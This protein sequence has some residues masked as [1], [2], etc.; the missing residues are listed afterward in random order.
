MRTSVLDKKVDLPYYSFDKVFSYNAVFN[1][2]VGA[3]GLG[4]TYG[5]KKYVIKNAIK[6]GEQFIY[7]RRYKTELTARTTFFADIFQEFPDHDFRVNGHQA[8]MAPRETRDDKKRKWQVIGYFAALSNAQSKKSVAY[9]AVTMILFDEF[10]IEKGALHYLPNEA[11]AFNDF[12]S[13]V[14]RWKDKTRVLFMANSVSIMNPYFLEYDIKPEDA[15]DKGF[16]RKAEGFICAHLADSAEFST[17]VFRTKFGQF[18]KNTEYAEYAV[19]SQFSDNNDRMLGR[20]NPDAKYYATIETKLGAFSVWIDYAGP[21]YYVQAKRPKQEMV[22]T[23]VPERMEQGKYL[24][25]YSDKFSQY[26]RSGFKSGKVFFD[27]PKTRNAFIEI[28]KR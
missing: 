20:K 17:G 6:T 8:E 12:Y 13:T 16:I 19:A 14:D 11:K 15:D 24:L 21:W 3:R 7:L 2:V 26:L 27:S 18:I 10:I 28:F 5:A 4:K 25:L 9:P 22:Y 1:F 23:V